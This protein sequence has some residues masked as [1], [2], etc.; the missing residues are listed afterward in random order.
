MYNMLT[1]SKSESET[2]V[3]DRKVVVSVGLNVEYAGV[4][5][6]S[7][8]WLTAWAWNKAGRPLDA[9]ITVFEE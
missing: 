7:N 2:F 9:V 5:N 1:P 8:R 4:N 3:N 6:H